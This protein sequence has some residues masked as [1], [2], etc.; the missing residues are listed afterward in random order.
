MANLLTRASRILP[1]IALTLTMSGCELVGDILE[2]GFWVGVIIAVAII[3]ILVWLV[4]KLSGGG[5]D[6]GAPP[7]R[8]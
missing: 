6:R 4:R 2:F 7:P 1:L 8:A 5:R 3:A